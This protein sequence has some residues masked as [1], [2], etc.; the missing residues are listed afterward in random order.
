MTAPAWEK[1]TLEMRDGN[2]PITRTI[3]AHFCPLNQGVEITLHQTAIELAEWAAS[4]QTQSAEYKSL[5]LRDG[6][7][8]QNH[9]QDHRVGAYA[10]LAVALLTGL[11]WRYINQIGGNVGSLKVVGR[12]QHHY[13]LLPLQTYT[14]EDLACILATSEPP[15]PCVRVIGWAWGWEIKKNG[16]QKAFNTG[17]KLWWWLHTSKLHDLCELPQD[18]FAWLRSLPRGYANHK[19]Q[20][21]PEGLLF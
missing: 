3:A 7:V 5:K 19:P 11:P 2:T 14:P 16:I 20:P 4:R 12:S 15:D 1:I 6:Q 13:D 10:G 8:Q 21:R 17:R 9:L 18:N